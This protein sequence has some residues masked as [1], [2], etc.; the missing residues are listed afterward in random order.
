MLA[1]LLIMFAT[2]GI[3]ENKQTSFGGVKLNLPK[4]DNLCEVKNTGSTAEI[5]EISAAFQLKAQNKL[6]AYYEDCLHLESLL[7]GSV[8]ASP[9]YIL[10]VAFNTDPNKETVYEHYTAKR[11]NEEMASS[12]SGLNINEIFEQVEKG[13][14][15]T[16]NDYDI[17]LKLAYDAPINLGILDIGDAVFHG[18]IMNISDGT[19]DHIV[20]GLFSYLLVNGIPIFVYKYKPYKDKQTITDLLSASKYYAARLVY[21]N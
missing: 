20:G 1:A 10:I 15:Q 14:N 8:A 17:D 13:A 9:E 16:L 12:V 11:F 2:Q 6:L 7:K 19:K 18:M 4:P 5:F 21:S 3:A